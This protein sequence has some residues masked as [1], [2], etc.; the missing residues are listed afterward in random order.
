M[1]QV[2]QYQVNFM[3][4]NPETNRFEAKKSKPM[5]EAAAN[6]LIENMKEN[7]DKYRGP[8]KQRAISSMSA[9]ASNSKEYSSQSADKASSTKSEAKAA[10]TSEQ[11][12][13]ILSRLNDDKYFN[14]L[15]KAYPDHGKR[16]SVKSKHDFAQHNRAES[17]F[18]AR[19]VR[20]FDKAVELG[21]NPHQIMGGGTAPSVSRNTTAN[22]DDIGYDAK[23]WTQD[24]QVLTNGLLKMNPNRDYFVV[25]NPAE[26]K[27]SN[28]AQDELK[29]NEKS[30]DFKSFK[31]TLLKLN[32]QKNGALRADPQ[33]GQWL[34]VD[35]KWLKKQNYSE[36]TLI[37]FSNEQR[38]VKFESK[39]L[40]KVGVDENTGLYH[41]NISDDMCTLHAIN[42][43][44]GKQVANPNVA[45]AFLESDMGD[46]NSRFRTKSDAETY[47]VDNKPPNVSQGVDYNQGK[48]LLEFLADQGQIDSS[49]KNTAIFSGELQKTPADKM[50][51]KQ[52]ELVEKGVQLD[53]ISAKADEL[54]ESGVTG[55]LLGRSSNTHSYSLNYSEQTEKWHILDSRAKGVSEGFEKPSDAIKHLVGSNKNDHAMATLLA[56]QPA[57][58]S[59]GNNN[60]N[61]NN[62][63][64]SSNEPEK[65]D[66][67]ASKQPAND[68]TSNNNSNEPEK[69]DKK[70]SKE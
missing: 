32:E 34:P 38:A 18:M 6:S 52:K 51:D 49:W 68:S 56:K 67:E 43:L 27:G 70:A 2:A 30:A 14:D 7:K 31:P 22:I 1:A 17:I 23:N 66:K 61:N 8:W 24:A 47:N 58:H 55:M 13:G 41:E 50:T 29:E 69:A 25:A 62:N 21:K 40:G 26:K 4:K 42:H 10:P 3:L 19:A 9:P 11:E 35:D 59:I 12:K 48:A 53:D 64:N 45:Q 5:S 46:K 37:A 60:N 28:N 33:S 39:D 44:I 57:N 63:N 16:K 20:G 65:V 15:Q 54:A 36:S